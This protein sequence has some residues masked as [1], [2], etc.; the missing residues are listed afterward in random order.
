MEKGGERLRTRDWSKVGKRR[1]HWD[2]R[3]DDNAIRRMGEWRKY[4]VIE[5]LEKAC[6]MREICC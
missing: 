3:T 5:I 6:L 2:E 4:W 1:K